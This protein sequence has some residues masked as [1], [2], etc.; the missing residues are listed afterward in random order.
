MEKGESPTPP[1]L[2]RI[3]RWNALWIALFLVG[4]GWI[5]SPPFVLGVLLGGILVLANFHL[6]RKIIER[7]F[8]KERPSPKRGG[9]L[10]AIKLLAWIP[11]MVFLIGYLKIDPIGL[12]L[13][14]TTLL[15]AILFETITSLWTFQEGTNHG[16]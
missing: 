10:L 13:G 2:A 8:Q 7:L 1:K 4:S 5:S 11:I 9:I 6:L 14:A 16:T 3:E 15:L 12:T